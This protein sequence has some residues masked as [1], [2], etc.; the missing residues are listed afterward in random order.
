MNFRITGFAGG[1]T[2]VVV[3]L[4]DHDKPATVENFVSYIRSGAYSNMFFDRLVPGFVLQGGD[5]DAQDRTNT[6]PGL[7]AYN[8][9]DTYV[10]NFYFTPP[11]PL[12][13]QSEF[14]VGPFVSNTKGTLALAF[15]SGGPGEQRLFFNLV[16]NSSLDSRAIH[17]LWPGN[18]RPECPGY[19]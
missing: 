13:I 15:P 8:I 19:F 5:Y 4:F 10:Q 1:P 9:Y 17:R 14:Y 12:E 7:T 6:A 18:R 11:L 2:N 3:E 16:D